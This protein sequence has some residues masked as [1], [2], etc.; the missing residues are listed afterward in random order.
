MTVDALRQSFAR[1]QYA[2]M[3]AAV[4]EP[5]LGFLWRYVLARAA[6]GALSTGDHDVP[7]AACAYADTVMEHLLGRL[8][9]RVEEL[10]GLRLD[11]TYSYLRVYRTGDALAPHR[12]REACE[13]SVSVNL[14]QEPPSAWPLWIRG[15]TGPEAIHLEPGDALVYRGIEREHWRE[16]Y[17]GVRLAQVFLHYVDREGPHA[18]WRFDRREGLDLSVPLPI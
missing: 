11:P 12:D 13:I 10:T 7:G 15:Q 6:S 5:L 9:P 17:D 18:R 14:G 3:R 16:R 1:H 2:V 4:A 8:Q